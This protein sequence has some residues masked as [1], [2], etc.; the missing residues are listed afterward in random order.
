MEKHDTILVACADAK[1]RG[2]LRYVL[3]ERFNLLESANLRQTLLLLEQNMDCVT[4]VVLATSVFEGDEVRKIRS[5][6]TD[7]LLGRVPVIIITEEETP[8]DLGVYFRW[9]ASDV[10]PLAYDAYA[11]LRRIETITQLHL[12]RQHLETVVQEQAD[13]LRRANDDMVD[14]LSSIIEYR[15]MESG[16]HILRIR[17]YTRILMEEVMHHC[18]EYQLTSRQVTII[19]SASALHDIGKIAIPDEILTKPGPL[20][21]AQWDIMKTHCATGCSI[22]DS[23]GA[24]ADQEY[25]RYAHNICH[26]HHE[27]WDGSGYPEGLKGDGIPV[28]AQVVGLAD[29]YEALTSKRVYKE[30]CSFNQ[31]MNMILQGECGSFSPKLLECFKNAAEQFEAL[32]EGYANGLAP[33]QALFDMTLPPPGEEQENSLSRTRAKYYALVHYIGAFLVEV[34]LDRKLFHVVYNPYPEI[35]RLEGITTLHQM[36]ALML[37]QIVVPREREKMR[38]L[39][40]EGIPQFVREDLRRSTYR[41]HY[42]MEDG[43]EGPFEMTLLRIASASRSSLAL[44]CR[45]TEEKTA[46]G[47]DREEVDFSLLT[48]NA[49]I[50][51]NDCD[52]TLSRMNPGKGELAGYSA[53]EIWQQFDGRLSG[54]IHPEDRSMVR[55]ETTRQLR[56]GTTVHLEHRILMKDGSVQWVDNKS[57]LFQGE[58]GREYLFGFF[59]DITRTREEYTSLQEKH[60][61]YRGILAQ[62][63]TILFDWD[64][65]KDTLICSDS[66]NRTFGFAPPENHIHSWLAHNPHFHPDDMPLLL[67]RIGILH[68]GSDHEAIEVR[69]AVRW[70]RYVWYRFR[71]HAIRSEDKTLTNIVGV[72]IQVETEKQA[73]RILKDRADRDSLT[74]LLNKSAGRKQAETYLSYYPGGV[75][76]AMLIIDLDN[77]KQVNDQYGHLFGDAVLTKVAQEIKGQFKEQDIVCR[78]GG[79]EFMVLVRGMSDRQLLEN[80]C[81]QLISSLGNSLRGQYKKLLLSCSVGIALAPEHGTTYH[82]LFNHADQALYQAKGSGKNGFCFYAPQKQDYSEQMVRFTAVSNQIDS[83]EEPSLAEDNIIRHI[84]ELLHSLPDVDE[85]INRVITLLGSRMNVSR[86]YIFENTPDNRFCNNTFEW[87]N[88]GIAPEIQK[89]QAIS[90]ETDIPN[91][92]DHFNEQGI[93]YCPDISVLPRATYDIVAPQGIKSMLHCAIRQ[94]GVF[95]GYIGFDECV[96]Q[97]LWTKEEIEMLRYISN[98]L[99]IFLLKHREQEQMRQQSDDL[100]T[101]MNNQNACIYIIDPDTWEL[102]YS[103]ER[104]RRLM[105][106]AQPGV[107]CYQGLMGRQEPCPGCPALGIREKKTDRVILQDEKLGTEFLAEATMVRWSGK[108]RCLMT[109]RALPRKKM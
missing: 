2:H 11:M 95:R 69:I 109:S 47:M 8:K 16:H 54:L 20:T 34:N 25:L 23:L 46:P 108:E 7:E 3:N 74:R 57:R 19:A 104:T 105:P 103:N 50:C 9:G 26:Y 101:L 77:F 75:S 10:I 35:V 107:P 59:T 14:V 65:T 24:M 80:R 97:R 41:F 92:E 6:Q 84:F 61:L 38:K 1:N 63:Q 55:E 71:M 28:C 12:H 89:L 82:E 98:L 43:G 42:R 18:P 66:W 51:R 58:D 73:E 56:Q 88:Q 45:K 29:A 36:A 79:D 68:G 81:R 44:L 86:V 87:C 93:F 102:Y 91:Y 33:E 27:R 49:Y 30:A 48:D 85:A 52:F 39:I 17:N 4:A 83:D 78:I 99:S 76:C 106:G 90:Y 40:Y 21:P 72:I 94:E 62:T 96:E 31:A 5:Q 53:A 15:S 67:D 64:V 37:D 70:G 60:Q 13:R 22:L 100:Q 32:T